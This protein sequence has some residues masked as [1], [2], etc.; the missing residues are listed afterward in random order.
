MHHHNKLYRLDSVYIDSLPHLQTTNKKIQLSSF[1]K[2]DIKY[3]F[4][5]LVVSEIDARRFYYVTPQ[6][7]KVNYIDNIEV[8]VPKCLQMVWCESP[9]FFC[10]PSETEG[11]FIDTLFHEIKLPE[12]PFEEHIIRSNGKPTE[13]YNRSSYI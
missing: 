12:N 10:A 1:E 6:A 7:N 8:V 11:D 9:P 2:L 3:G 13:Q 4:W 5:K